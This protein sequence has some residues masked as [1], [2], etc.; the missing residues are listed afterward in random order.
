MPVV[1][2]GSNIGAELP[3]SLALL[4]FFMMKSNNCKLNFKI[5]LL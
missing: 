4:S 1:S 2:L 5:V 3:D